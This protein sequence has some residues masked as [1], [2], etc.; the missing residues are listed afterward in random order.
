MDTS[1]VVASAAVVAAVVS[2]VLA[3]RGSTRATDV[4]RQDADTKRAAE[5]RAD[6]ADARVE[7]R[8]ARTDAREARVMAAEAHRRAEEVVS[9]LDWII[10]TI[11]NADMTMDRLR[12][13]V[14]NSQPPVS[15]T[16][17]PDVH[18]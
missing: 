16:R 9:Y 18:L 14:G 1:D 4:T 15:T 11:N 2:A 5:L 13:L 6:A 7:A 12:D 17:R 8:Q 10:R 3:Y